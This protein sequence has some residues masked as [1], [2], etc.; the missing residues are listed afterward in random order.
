VKRNLLLTAVI[1]FL[2]IFAVSISRGDPALDEVSDSP[3]DDSTEPIT[4]QAAV[5]QKGSESPMKDPFTP[6]DIGGPA[7]AWKYEDLTD[8]EK[9]VV[10]HGKAEDQTAIQA[11]YAETAAV[12]ADVAK[13][14]AAAI[15]IGA[16]DLAEGAVP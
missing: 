8:D 2:I 1:G 3:V 9:A 16:N 4:G 14:H 10:D 6:Y 7:A 12:I 11:A 5:P 13:A 15:Q